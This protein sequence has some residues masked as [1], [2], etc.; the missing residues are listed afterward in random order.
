MDN[1]KIKYRNPKKV[2]VSIKDSPYH[3]IT[4]NSQMEKKSGGAERKNDLQMV[5]VRMAYIQGQRWNKY[6][7]FW[8]PVFWFPNLSAKLLILTK[9]AL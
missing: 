2:E 9:S 3:K 7:P 8:E 4:Q 1:Y 5:M 6:F